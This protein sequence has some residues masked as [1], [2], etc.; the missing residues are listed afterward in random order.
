M[1]IEVKPG[2]YILA[3]SGGVDSMVL[4]DILSTKNGIDLV[5]AHYNHGIRYDSFK[6]ETLVRHKTK[7]YG[8]K[9][10]VGY[11]RLGPGAS[12]EAARDAR[13]KFLEQTRL[14]HK[15]AAVITAHHQDDLIETAFINLIRGTGRKG[16]VAINANKK[17]LRPLLGYPKSKIYEYARENNIEWNEDKTNADNKYLRNYIRGKLTVGLSPRQRVN[18]LKNIDTV[19]KT[20]GKI[21]EYIATLSQSVYKN[22][23]IDRYKFGNLPTELGDE[24]LAYWMRQNQIRDFDRQSVNRLNIAL[25]TAKGT[26]IHQIKGDNSLIIGPKTAKFAI[27]A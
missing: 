1:K 12:E 22:N 23:S 7:N 2:K 27:T 5:V 25:K 13:Y 11:G 9:Y 8:H 15:A 17:V 24:L 26:T 16:L 21:D 4:L 6:D 14:K 10:E 3:V 19:A 18:I 20:D